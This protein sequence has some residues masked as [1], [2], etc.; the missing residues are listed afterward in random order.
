MPFDKETEDKIS[1]DRR[2]ASARLDAMTETERNHI[3]EV[4]QQFAKKV[5]IC[6]PDD[7]PKKD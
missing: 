2:E 5:E 6:Y 3:R 1:T 4:G 7:R